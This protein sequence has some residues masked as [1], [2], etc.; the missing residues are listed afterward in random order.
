GR[1]T[2]GR[3]I[4]DEWQKKNDGDFMRLPSTK[5][6][7]QS[8]FD[9]ISTESDILATFTDAENW[10][11]A[12]GETYDPRLVGPGKFLQE[13]VDGEVLTF[14]P[15]DLILFKSLTRDVYMVALVINAF[16]DP[17][18]ANNRFITFSYKRAIIKN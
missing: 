2:G 3:T 8:I 15:G 6:G 16:D 7:N 5:G 10:L 9:V 17:D 18:D 11:N 13:R 14:K 1:F 12:Q 4:R